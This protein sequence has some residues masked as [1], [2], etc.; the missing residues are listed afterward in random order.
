MEKGFLELGWKCEKVFVKKDNP[1]GRERPR[2]MCSIEGNH[3]FSSPVQILTVP[4]QLCD[5]GQLADLGPRL[6]ISRMRIIIAAAS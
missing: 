1:A 5:L 6:L 2:K 4:F 3:R